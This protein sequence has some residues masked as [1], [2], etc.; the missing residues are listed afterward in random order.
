M[1]TKQNTFNKNKKNPNKNQ[2]N[3]NTLNIT[4]KKIINFTKIKEQH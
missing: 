1:I 3:F 2:S 4:K